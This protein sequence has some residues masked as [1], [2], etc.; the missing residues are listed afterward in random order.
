MEGSPGGTEESRDSKV[1]SCSKAEGFQEK[2][3]GIEKSFGRDILTSI[4]ICVIV[5]LISY[6]SELMKKKQ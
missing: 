1:V 4:D 5:P 2:Y 6:S 3:G